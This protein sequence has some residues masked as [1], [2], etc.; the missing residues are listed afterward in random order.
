MYSTKKIILT[1]PESVGKSTLT[2]K[3]AQ[4][5]KMPYI[6]EIAR[7]YIENLNRPYKKVDVIEIAKLQIEAE[8]G[9]VKL[10]PELVFIDTDLIITK[11]WLL[12]LYND[13]PIWIDKWLRD[14]S[15][16]L[17][18]LCYYDIEWEFDPVRENPETRQYFFEK[19]LNEIISYNIKYG[20]VKGINDERLNNAL[21]I[22]NNFY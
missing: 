2:K 12:H 10:K 9:I 17:H 7:D 20:I 8:K 21:S 15:A 14:N 6:K 1:G 22:V 18:L 3:L 4:H 19:Y 5:F 13:Y 16:Y 11:I